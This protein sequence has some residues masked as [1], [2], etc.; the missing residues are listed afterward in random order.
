LDTNRFAEVD[1]YINDLFIPSD[2]TIDAALEAT[3]EAGMPEIQISPC[4]GKLL[5]LLAKLCGA[6]RILELGTLGGYSTIWL[7]RALP[8]DGRLV[9]LELKPEHA[10]VARKSIARAGLADRVEVRVGPALESLAQLEADHAEPFD[11]VFID[12]DKTGYTDY[13][14]WA[15]RL[16]HPG[17]LILA[18]NVVRAG[19]VLDPHC[20]DE[21]VQGVRAFNAALAATP[22]VEALILQQVGK[23]SHDGLAIA[24]VKE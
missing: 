18:D 17:S 23:K 9:S 10:D 2:P 4:Q 19:K 22:K 11:L 6:R 14:N 5:H 8:A 20:P 24:R 7:G 16:T 3:T 21:A 15:L 13:L 1:Q 12:A